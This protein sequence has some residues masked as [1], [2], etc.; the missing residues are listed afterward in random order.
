MHHVLHYLCIKYYNYLAMFGHGLPDLA[1][2]LGP[3]ILRPDL[4]AN[5]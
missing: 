2:G 4:N 5:Q 1:L 3:R